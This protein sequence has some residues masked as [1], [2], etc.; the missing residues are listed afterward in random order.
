LTRDRASRLHRCID[1]AWRIAYV[2]AYR[3]LRVWWLVGRTR[4]QGAFV[5]VWRDG[6]LLVI[7]NS[8]RRSVTIPSGNIDRGETPV[9]AAARELAEEVGIEVSPE[10]L[11][12]VSELRLD[13]ESKQ[14]RAHIFEL[15][16]PPGDTT[17]VRIDH[18][19]VVWAAFTAPDDLDIGGLSPHVVEYLR[20]FPQ[21]R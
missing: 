4:S 12:F 3:V 6:K 9:Q 7:R 15:I 8:Y 10:A 14:E 18:R 19:E 2:V 13:F 17:E 21:E 11:R 16:L 5:A 20:R 1:A